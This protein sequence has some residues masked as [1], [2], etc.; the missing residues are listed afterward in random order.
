MAVV[1]VLFTPEGSGGSNV[2]DARMVL[3]ALR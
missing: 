2:I 1:P 3:E